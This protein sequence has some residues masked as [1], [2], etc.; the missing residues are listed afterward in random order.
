MEVE[1]FCV[2]DI[3]TTAGNGVFPYLFGFLSIASI[4]VIGVSYK[5]LFMKKE[6]VN[7]E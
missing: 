3:F 6:V 1:F 7:K 5:T 4:I 2:E